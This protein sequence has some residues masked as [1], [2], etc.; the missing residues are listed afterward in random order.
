MKGSLLAL[1]K[2]T[3]CLNRS[4]DQNLRYFSVVLHDEPL[5]VET[6]HLYQLVKKWKSIEDVTT[7]VNSPSIALPPALPV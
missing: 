7:T 4:C 5:K 2:F 1:S 6:T 3:I